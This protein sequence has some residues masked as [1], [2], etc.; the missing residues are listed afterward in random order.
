MQQLLLNEYFTL[1]NDLVFKLVMTSLP[2]ALGKAESPAL[3]FSID[4]ETLESKDSIG[5]GLRVNDSLFLGAQPVTAWRTATLRT[6]DLACELMAAQSP[7]VK[8]IE[9]LSP[10][11]AV[12]FVQSKTS[13]SKKMTS[14]TLHLSDFG[15]ITPFEDK[16]SMV[17]IPLPTEEEHFELPLSQED[18]W[19][20][21]IKE[22]RPHT[23]SSI[24]KA[25]FS[26]DPIFKVLQQTLDF[27]S[28]QEAIR[29]LAER[30]YRRMQ[31]I[32]QVEE[33]AAMRA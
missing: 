1:T 17:I 11:V 9:D 12:S 21:F 30:R 25:L 20:W 8:N 7:A 15:F 23:L 2:H 28:D 33:K 4:S 13:Y 10:I 18:Q 14:R 19:R 32:E 22:A 31:E 26:Q 29:D 3:V 6:K 24:I 5:I 27:L 16:I